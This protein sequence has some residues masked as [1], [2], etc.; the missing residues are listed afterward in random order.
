MSLINRALEPEGST[1]LINNNMRLI[2]RVYGIQ[3]Q[4]VG[5]IME[6][7]HIASIIIEVLI[8]YLRVRE[9]NI[10]VY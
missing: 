7:E 8:V 10:S 1:C 5:D 2:T 6:I 4:A 9:W 3:T